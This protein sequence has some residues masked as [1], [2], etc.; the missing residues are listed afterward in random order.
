MELCVTE[1]LCREP[2]HGRSRD[3]AAKSAA[4]AETYVISQDEQ[5]VRSTLGCLSLLREIQGR[6]FC[7]EANVAFKGRLRTRQNIL[8][9]CR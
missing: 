3:R 2:V 5:Y 8:R 4:C 6:V 7:S 1:P 9:A